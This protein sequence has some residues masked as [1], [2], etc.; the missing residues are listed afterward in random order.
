MASKWDGLYEKNVDIITKMVHEVPTD[1]TLSE[2][3]CTNNA[4]APEW[5]LGQKKCMVYKLR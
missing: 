3:Q 2:M 4:K 5:G 1:H